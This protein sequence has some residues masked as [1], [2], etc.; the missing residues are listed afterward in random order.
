MS[1]SSDR[2]FEVPSSENTIIRPP[3]EPSQSVMKRVIT[4]FVPPTTSGFMQWGETMMILGAFIAMFI[5]IILVYIYYNL[6]DYQNRISVITNAYLFG[7][8]PQQRFEQYIKN[9]QSEV[10]G[11]AMTTIQNATNQLN[12]TNT[13]LNDKANRLAKQV[14][15]D[16]PNN[17]AETNNLGISIQT[18]VAQIRDTISKLGGAFMLNNYMTDGAVKT[19]QSLKTPSPSSGS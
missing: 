1:S 7:A 8:N 2:S 10:V 12:S 6:R 4:L 13:R 18:N 15:V 19:V 16:V 17:N 11:S 5:S 14:D 3:T 9:T